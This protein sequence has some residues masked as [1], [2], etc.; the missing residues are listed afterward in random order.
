MQMRRTND[1][2]GD[3]EMD[4][5]EH[6]DDTNGGWLELSQYHEQVVALI[7]QLTPLHNNGNSFWLP[8]NMNFHQN[9]G[10]SLSTLSILFSFW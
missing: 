4:I 5:D 3:G 1:D 7:G 8:S 6:D 9:R 10:H 2:N